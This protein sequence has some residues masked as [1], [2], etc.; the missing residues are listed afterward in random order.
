MRNAFNLHI[1]VSLVLLLAFTAFS[2]CRRDTSNAKRYELKGKVLTVEK[3]KHLVTVSHEEIKD[4]MEPM[5]MPFTV[6]DE[7]VFD[8][9][10]AGDQITATLV[11]DGM[12]SWLE[13][14]V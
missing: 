3:D 2:G 7:W 13:N 11:V 14:V 9:A 4:F 5:T 8:Q 10:A 6:R 1:T 12:E